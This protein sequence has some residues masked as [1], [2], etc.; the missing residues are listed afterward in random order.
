[1]T[2]NVSVLQVESNP[3]IALLTS[4]DRKLGWLTQNMS[5]QKSKQSVSS[6]V[7]EVM[8]PNF[9]SHDIRVSHEA[10]T[11]FI[12]TLRRVG[13]YIGRNLTKKEMA[14]PEYQPY[15]G[16]KWHHLYQALV[17][18]GIFEKATTHAAY[19]EFICKVLPGKKPSNISRSFY[20]NYDNNESIIADMMDVF[21]PVKDALSTPSP[22]SNVQSSRLKR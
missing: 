5:K 12:D 16:W 10:T 8:L 15:I 2:E 1:M 9:V 21:R 13:Q 3:L 11:L 17:G 6:V 7:R 4:I 20:R 14:M 22:G 18:L 19:A